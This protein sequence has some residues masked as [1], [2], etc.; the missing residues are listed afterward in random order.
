MLQFAAGCCGVLRSV[1][2]RCRV[3]QCVVVCCSVLQCFEMCCSVL[4][5]VAGCDFKLSR[6]LVCVLCYRVAKAHRIPYL[7]RSFSAKVTYI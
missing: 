1:A 3:L 5:C 2:E 6:W 4:Q 7:Y